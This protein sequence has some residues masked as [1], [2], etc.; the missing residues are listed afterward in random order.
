MANNNDYDVKKNKS[1]EAL[2]TYFGL[3]YPTYSPMF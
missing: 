2:I 1:I 3:K